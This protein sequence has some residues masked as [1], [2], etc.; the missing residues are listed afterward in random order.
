M[1]E[2]SITTLVGWARIAV[3]LGCTAAYLFKQLSLLEATAAATAICGLLGGVGFIS[4]QDAGK[5]KPPA[6]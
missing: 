4:A 5:P 2:V 1:P 6:V 3:I